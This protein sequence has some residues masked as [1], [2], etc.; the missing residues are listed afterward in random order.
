MKHLRI[1]GLVLV[2]VMGALL[3]L[4]GLG[5]ESGSHPEDSSRLPCARQPNQKARTGEVRLRFDGCHFAGYLY[6]PE[7]SARHFLE[8]YD[9]VLGLQ[10]GLEDLVVEDIRETGVSAHTRFAQVI[11][12]R[13]I[14]ES[15]VLVGQGSDGAIVSLHMNYHPSPEVVSGLSLIHI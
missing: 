11:D 12:G 10:H 3:T 13:P 6:A 14:F 7:S 15:S 8:F 4:H 1:G 9:S 5:G 2:A